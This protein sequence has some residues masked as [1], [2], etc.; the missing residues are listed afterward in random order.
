MMNS[1]YFPRHLL[2]LDTEQK[3]VSQ[4]REAK[5]KIKDKA[6][7]V[8]FD[9]NNKIKLSNKSRNDLTTA[10]K[11]ES[12]ARVSYDQGLGKVVIVVDV[13]LQPADEPV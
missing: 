4:S 13:E 2:Q 8:R 12:L 9:T 10:G 6:P 5:D 3:T 1:Q 7:A 11:G